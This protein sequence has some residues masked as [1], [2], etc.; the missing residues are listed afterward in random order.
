MKQ[1]RQV[2]VL[3]TVSLLSSARAMASSE[4][5]AMTDVEISEYAIRMSDI[6]E[7]IQYRRLCLSE[8]TRCLRAEFSRHGISYDDKEPLK[9]RLAIMLAGV[10]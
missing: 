7:K 10:H 2:L 1:F 9:R 4:V 3:V 8:D 5:D 6:M